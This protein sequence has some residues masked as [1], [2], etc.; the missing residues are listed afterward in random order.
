MEARALAPRPCSAGAARRAWTLGGSC[1]T[2]LVGAA[3]VTM[4][5]TAFRRTLLGQARR[6]RV[7]HVLGAAAV[8]PP[9]QLR[10]EDD[11]V[12]HDVE[13]DEQDDRAAERLQRR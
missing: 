3:H 10:A 11:D 1:E 7:V 6:R 12:G 5:R 9:V 4:A 2:P 8:P 13:P